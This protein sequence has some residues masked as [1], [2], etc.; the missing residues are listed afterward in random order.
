MIRSSDASWQTTV[1]DPQP[2]LERYPEYGFALGGEL[3]SFPLAVA[4][5]GSFRSYFRDKPSPFEAPEANVLSD[6]ET[7][8]SA[9]IGLIE[10]SPANTRLVVFGSAEL[11]NDTVYQISANFAGDR[12]VSNLQMVANAID[13]F[14]EDA[15]LASIRSRGSV[16]RILPPISQ[17]A[18]DRWVV[19]N[20][21]VAIIGL[22]LIGALWQVQRRA[23]KPI[24]L[25]PPRTRDLAAEDD[26]KPDAAPVKGGA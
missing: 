14:T 21:A 26:R 2:D 25:L 1:A 22:I 24:E 7:P 11:V 20:Y 6:P 19:I 4:V 16:A 8:P 18:Q 5:E 17:E 13:W 23:E 15:S 9:P 10:R 3:A 12:F